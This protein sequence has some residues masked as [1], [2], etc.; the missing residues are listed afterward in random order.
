MDLNDTP[1]ASTTIINNERWQV[2]Q[3]QQELFQK[4][5]EQQLNNG[6]GLA[7]AETTTDSTT[8]ITPPEHFG[9]VEPGIYRSNTFE[10]VNFPFLA[11]LG[12]KHLLLLS[13]E[14]PTR[15][16]L[17]FLDDQGIQLHHLGLHAWKPLLMNSMHST[18]SSWRPIPEELVK[19][20][21]EFILLRLGKVEEPILI[22]CTLGIHDTGTVVG[23]LR[24]ALGW[25]LNSIVVEYRSFAGS[26]ARYFNEQFIELF[27][28]DLI[29][30]SL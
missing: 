27:D 30:V 8:I 1:N 5:Q 28:L 23:C 17:Q 20:A 13:A 10:S 25:N 15:E 22:C 19:E 12:L 16:V 9:I 14:M 6:G 3:S 4:P 7:Q 24:K 29:S 11:Q 26:R 2:N 18:S 21:L